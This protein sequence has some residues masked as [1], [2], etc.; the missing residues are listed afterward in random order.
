MPSDFP[1]PIAHFG[2][3]A[4]EFDSRCCLVC[5]GSRRAEG[6][7]HFAFTPCP[8]ACC[9]AAAPAMTLLPAGQVHAARRPLLGMARVDVALPR[10]LRS[11]A[12]V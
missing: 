2:V 11:A 7:V 3:N 6:Q 10:P 9:I 4:G 8:L 12:A 1:S 5:C